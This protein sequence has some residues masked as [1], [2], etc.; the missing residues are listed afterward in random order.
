MDQPALLRVA[1]DDDRSG[2]AALHPFGAGI[3]SQAAFDLFRTGT[4]TLVALLGQNG[5]DFLL[6]ELDAF[7]GQTGLWRG[8]FGSAHS[9]AVAQEQC[10]DHQTIEV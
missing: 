7:A 1:R 4:M 10:C 6:E 8:P 9:P 2:F 5:P 3:Q